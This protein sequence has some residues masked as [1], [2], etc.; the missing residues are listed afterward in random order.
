MG[1]TA[2]LRFLP[3]S[4]VNRGPGTEV[5]G[6]FSFMP[7]AKPDKTL[8]EL[9]EI[10]TKNFSQQTIREGYNIDPSDLE[11]VGRQALARGDIRRDGTLN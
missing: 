2:T 8:K 11:E 5:P 6:L 3:R 4:S 9:G 1:A 10:I 7:K